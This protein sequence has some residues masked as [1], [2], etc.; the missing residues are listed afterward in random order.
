MGHR[1][2]FVDNFLNFSMETF[3]I[4]DRV[5]HFGHVSNKVKDALFAA[6]GWGKRQDFSISFMDVCVYCTPILGQVHMWHMT[7]DGLIPSVHMGPYGQIRQWSSI[8]NRLISKWEIPQSMA[9]EN[10]K[11]MRKHWIFGFEI[12]DNPRLVDGADSWPICRHNSR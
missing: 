2:S 9:I 1:P 10:V 12:W 7:Y 5:V 6:Q 3:P 4:L 11:M 8:K